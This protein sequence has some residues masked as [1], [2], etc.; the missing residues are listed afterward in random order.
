MREYE[1]KYLNEGYKHI[2][3]CDEA[4]RGPWAGPLVAAAVMLPNDYNNDLID[5]S[6]KLSEQQ[7]TEL[8]EE[9]KK[10][11]IAYEIVVKDAAYV[12]EHNPKKSSRD[13]MTEGANKIMKQDTFVLVDAETLPIENSIGIIKGDQ[14][15][16]SIA[17]ASILAKHT[18][19]QLMFEID[20]ELPEYSFKNHKGYGTKKHQE[21]LLKYG[22]TKYHRK[23]YKPVKELLK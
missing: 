11:A 13:A 19:D 1:N 9:I 20:K 14:K 10:V 16:I 12:D 18:R 22:V 3:G 15:S 2:I 21:A 17:A 7:R 23:S 6:K 8:F 5:D 4:G